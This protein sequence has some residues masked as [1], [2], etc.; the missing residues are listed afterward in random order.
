VSLSEELNGK[1]ITRAYSIASPLNGNRFELCL[2]EVK[3]GRFSPHLFSMQ[4]GDTVKMAGPLG[5]FVPRSPLSDSIFVAVGTGIAPFRA[6]LLTPSLFEA[7]RNI[8]LIFGARYEHGLLY[9]DEFESL[10]AKHPNFR[11]TP[12][13]TRPA[14]KWTGRTGR[15]Q[16]HLLESVGDR[17]D[18]D[19][20]VCGMKEMVDDVRRLLKEMTFE[21][22]RIIYEK[23][24]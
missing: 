17:R 4:P 23:Y 19:V 5:T 15:V 14:D 21:R 2:N 11:F 20:Y 13:V 7:G 6:M 12:T 1:H 10:A 8:E 18:L 16:P 3:D 9:S 22:R 24:D